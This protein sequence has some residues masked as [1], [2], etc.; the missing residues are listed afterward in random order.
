MRMYQGIYPTSL[1]C[2]Q[3]LQHVAINLGLSPFV[4]RDVA[5]EANKLEYLC[6]ET[7]RRSDE[8]GFINVKDRSI[9]DKINLVRPEPPGLL[10][11]LPEAERN[12]RDKHHS[13]VCEQPLNRELARQERGVAVCTKDGDKEAESDDRAVWLEVSCVGESLAVKTLGLASAVEAQVG[14]THR[15]EV[16]QSTSS[17]D[18]D[19]PAK[20]L[21]RTVRQ[22]QERQKG[23][24]HDDEEAVDRNAVLGALAQEPGSTAFNRE[25]VQ[26]ASC[27]VGVGVTGREDT[28]DQKGVDKVGKSI[29]SQVA[30]GNDVRRGGSAALTGGKNI[31]ESGV[32]V[33]DDYANTKGSQDEEGTKTEVD[34]LKCG[35]DVSTGAL[36]LTRDHGDVLRADNAERGSPE[37]TEEALEAAK[38]TSCVQRAKDTGIAPV[39]EAV[40]ILLGVATNHLGHVSGVLFE[41][42]LRIVAYRDEGECV[43]N[44]DQKNFA[45][46]KPEFCF[47]IC[48]DS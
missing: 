40:C 9:P 41:T 17:D 45:A 32:V 3:I 8:G 11:Q 18:V 24:D 36:S 37:S 12:R 34:G 27:T 25:R 28:G 20:D 1:D 2:H 13:V 30:H 44:K 16:D 42:F 14:N 5:F 31:N 29:D 15:D 22:L 43:E 21:C 26:T 23:E 48:L 39:A 46:R 7:D 19:Q 35:L 47:S 10:V 4:N 6:P 38:I 33:R